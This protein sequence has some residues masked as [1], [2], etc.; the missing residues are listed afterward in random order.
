ML[1]SL[2]RFL[3]KGW[4][5]DYY[6][7]PNFHFKYYGFYWVTSWGEYT[8]VLFA[9]AILACIAIILGFKYRLSMLVFFLSFTYIELIDKTTYLNPKIMLK[10]AKIAIA[11][12]A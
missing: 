1:I 11:N 2:A 5:Y 9:I 10:Q 8:Y 7:K 3:L 6:I 12:N 4:V